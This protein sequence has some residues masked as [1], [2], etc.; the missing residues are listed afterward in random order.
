MSG[1]NLPGLGLFAVA[2]SIGLGAGA[3]LGDD[4]EGVQM[5]VAGPVLAVLDGGWRVAR[6]LPLVRS[7]KP[8]QLDPRF[9]YL[10]MWLWGLFWTGLGAYYLV[11]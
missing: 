2:F 10:P 6:G 5:L 4:R 3:A 11:R 7:A 1:F 9:L 8:G